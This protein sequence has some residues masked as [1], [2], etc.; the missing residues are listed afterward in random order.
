MNIN[1]ENIDD[2]TAILK[3]EIAQA[4]YETRVQDVLKDYR[5]KSKIDGFRPGTVPLGIVKKLH[6]KAILAEEVN[7]ILSESLT[8]YIEENKL[9]VL[10]EPLPNETVQKEIDWENQN[11]FEFAFDIAVAPEFEVKL[12]KRDKIDYYEINVDGKI[13]ESFINNYRKRFSEIKQV[14]VVTENELVKGDLIQLDSEGKVLAEGIEVKDVL[15]SLEHM[16]EVDIKSSFKGANVNQIITFCPYNAY[17]NDTEI[18]S[19]LKIDKEKVESIKDSEFQLT[20]KEISTFVDAEVNQVLFDKVFGEGTVNSVEEFEAKVKEDI[21]SNLSK[22][23]DYKLLL[24]A[25]DKLI[26]KFKIDLPVEF[27]KRWLLLT[28]TND[29]TK[30]KIDAEW[31]L[32]ANDLKW[33]LIKDK[34]TK[35]NDLKVEEEEII[36]Y[37]KEVTLMQFKQ[38]GLT[39]IPDEQLTQ[40]AQQL[41]QNQQE[42]RKIYEKKFEDK[43]IGYIK[44]TVKLESIEISADD[45]NKLFEK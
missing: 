31:D 42:L 11:D 14:D 28:N 26:T 5:K 16:K 25:K 4:D 45:F 12:S 40:Y 7:K 20:I 2:L 8:K 43:V 1:R 6:G 23:S 19:M 38:Y 29:L 36:E 27:L 18:S 41:L 34:I 32:F 33:Q 39:S 15:L 9:N 17:Q 3:I 21:K 10:G 37:A 30:E 24:D 13:T 44:D 35:E 22:E